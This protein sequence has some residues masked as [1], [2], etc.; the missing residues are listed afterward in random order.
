[1]KGTKTL[2]QFSSKKLTFDYSSHDKEQGTKF[3]P[4]FSCH[5]IPSLPWIRNSLNSWMIKWGK[6]YFLLY[7]WCFSNLS[8]KCCVATLCVTNNRNGAQ[9][10]L[11]PIKPL[12]IGD[13]DWFGTF[14]FSWLLIHTWINTSFTGL[15]GESNIL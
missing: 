10:S 3:K 13:N 14:W 9:A 2:T 6:I 15:I 4:M 1:M 11:Y 8:N 7:V 12:L 5:S